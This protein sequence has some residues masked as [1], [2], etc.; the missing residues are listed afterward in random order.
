MNPIIQNELK[1]NWLKKENIELQ[2]KRRRRYLHFDRIIEEVSR[3]V[4][5]KVT[6]PKFVEKHAFFPLIQ[7]IQKARLYKRNPETKKKIIKTKERP[8]SYSAHFDAIIY[9]WYAEQIEAL[10][11]KRV[12]EIGISDNVIAYRSLGKSNLVFAKEVFD[13]IKTQKKS[14]AIALDIKGFYNSLDFKILKKSWTNILSSTNLPSDHYRIYKS[15]TRFSYVDIRDINTLLN[16]G[17][18]DVN[19]F[20]F[21]LGMDLLGLLRKNGKIKINI[22]KGVP[23]GTPISCVL[24]NLYMLNFDLAVSTEIARLGGIYRRYSDDIIVVCPS[25]E[26]DFIKQY[27]KNQI[28]KTN[29]IIEDSKTEV[30]FFENINNNLICLDEGGRNSKLQYL[31]VG[32]DGIRTSLR[33]RGYAKFERKMTKS[34]RGEV[35]NANRLSLSVAKR[36]IYEKF[37]PLGKM[38]YIGY[39]QRAA[40]ELNSGLIKKTVK[41]SRLFKK[42]NKK[43]TQAQVNDKKEPSGVETAGV[44]PASESFTN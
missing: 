41:A 6:N 28:N 21:F 8:I 29:L 14:V 34:I 15:V 17:E 37:T 35:R 23:Q 27:L 16:I 24:S 11:E 36:K 38:N 26:L 43:I 18:S 7:R 42:V 9:S 30:R 5:E 39:A 10:Y 25:A 32:F 22:N 19:K 3:P 40:K 12:L 31:G 20:R 13:F 2:Q 44:E 1:N 4:F 33:H